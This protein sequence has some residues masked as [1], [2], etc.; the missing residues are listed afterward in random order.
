MSNILFQINE[1]DKVEILT[2]QDNYIDLTA[3]DSNQVIT[4]AMPLK[5]GQFKKSFLSE[6]GFSAIVRT[7]T[8]D[9][10][11]T[12]LFDFGFSEIGAAFNA[13]TLGFDMSQIE[14]LALSH[15]HTDHT[16]GMVKLI[17]MIGKQGIEFVAHPSVF[18]SPR[19][20]KYSEDRKVFFPAFSRQALEKAGVKVIETKNPY[21]MLNGDVLFLGEI[22]RRTD[23][24]KGF[25]IA[26]FLE[27][28]IE[29]PDA[30]EDD[31]AIAMNVKGKGLVILSG[32]AH[33]GIVNTVIH[34]ITVTG[35]KKVYAVMGGFHL[36]GPLF[37]P[38]IDRTTEELNKINPTYIVPT[39]CTGRKA[40][41]NIEKEM[42]GQFILNMSGT[43]LTF[44]A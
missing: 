19:Y 4:R 1:V 36:S 9:R 6:H 43:K 38:I 8:D 33:A 44:A 30:I 34:A 39:H 2:L 21:P 26:R 32:C 11:R 25:P 13:E 17:Q 3:T 22:E 5:D 23:F 15:G 7:M 42:P 40:I 41:T 10:T 35:I 24:E 27:D 37:E 14:A 20:L 28:G 18:K 31:T 29:K 12:M 16:G